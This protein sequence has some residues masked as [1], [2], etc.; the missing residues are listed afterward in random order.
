MT[1]PYLEVSFNRMFE[2]GQGYVA[3]S[4]ATS[5]EGLILKSFQGACI[6][7]HPKVKQFY[8]YIKQRKFKQFGGGLSDGIVS[9]GLKEF[10]KEFSDASNLHIDTENPSGKDDNEDEGWIDT[11]STNIRKPPNS[12]LSR[13]ISNQVISHPP[14]FERSKLNNDQIEHQPISNYNLG[15]LPSNKNADVIC[16]DLLTDAEDSRGPMLSSEDGIDKK[17]IQPLSE[18]TG[19]GNVS[20]INQ[21]NVNQLSNLS[22]DLKRYVIILE[23]LGKSLF[24]ILLNIVG[25]LNKIACKHWKN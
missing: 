12:I 5:L 20:K 4:R 6:K 18:S 15:N 13:S 14:S 10:V 17:F 8:Q 24:F 16:I 1:I 19:Y 9:V 25:K 11:K 22:E 23:I 7:A 3:L 21:T 2:Y